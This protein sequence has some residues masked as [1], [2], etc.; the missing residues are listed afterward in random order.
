MVAV[1]IMGGLVLGPAEPSCS[2]KTTTGE[3]YRVPR[4]RSFYHI[5]VYWGGMQV[6]NETD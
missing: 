6:P 4:Q 5:A 2:L 3:G 1:R